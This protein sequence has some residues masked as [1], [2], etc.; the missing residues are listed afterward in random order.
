LLLEHKLSQQFPQLLVAQ[1]VQ[2]LEEV[3]ALVVAAI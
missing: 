3:A 1:Q 2:P